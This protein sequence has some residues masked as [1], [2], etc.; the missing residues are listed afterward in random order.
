MEGENAGDSGDRIQG[1]GRYEAI[2]HAVIKPK[3]GICQLTTANTN[4]SCE[5]IMGI[6][7]S[8]HSREG[9]SGASDRRE[10]APGKGEA[11]IIFAALPKPGGVKKRLAKEIG[12]QPA[13]ALY[14]EL[15][16]HTFRTGQHALDRGW[17]VYLFHD[18]KVKEGDVRAWVQRDFHFAAEQGENPGARIHHA[19]DYAFHHRAGKA[20]VIS[21]DIPG[22]GFDV[23]EEAS[24]RLDRVDVVMGP[25]RDGGC[26]LIGMKPPTKG[27]FRDLPWGTSNVFREAS[28]RVHTLG[29]TQST[30]AQLSDVD[31]AE[32]YRDYLMRK[33]RA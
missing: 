18:P 31:N 17:T 22:M 21:S 14:N 26:Y 3:K 28:E 33:S 10:K 7:G 19:F 4:H 24:S 16:I 6:S 23:I 27:F 13:A 30:L 8:A 11:L 1:S 25:A 12:V 15:A 2:V 5:H 20:V 32:T 9:L 29:L